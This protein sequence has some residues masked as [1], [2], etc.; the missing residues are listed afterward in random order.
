MITLDARMPFFFS[1]IINLYFMVKI[2]LDQ[3]LCCR[4]P[5]CLWVF[6]SLALSLGATNMV[7]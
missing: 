3:G 5:T 6:L 7:C 2:Q 4:H 1:K